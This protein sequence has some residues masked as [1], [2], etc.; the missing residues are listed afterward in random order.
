[1]LAGVIGVAGVPEAARLAAD[2]GVAGSRP[3]T[4]TGGA[5]WA[6]GNCDVPAERA[7]ADESGAGVSFFHQA[8]RA[9]DWQPSMATRSGAM[10][11]AFVVVLFMTLG[12]LS[13]CRLIEMRF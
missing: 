10:I 5:D 8:R 4:E 11:N 3:G 13:V 6:D 12:R 1:M 9:P 2:G 7:T